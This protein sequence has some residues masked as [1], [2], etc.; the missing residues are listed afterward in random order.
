[1]I[2]DWHVTIDPI[3]T[4]LWN[5]TSSDTTKKGNEPWWSRAVTNAISKPFCTVFLKNGVKSRNEKLSG[6]VGRNLFSEE[7]PRK[8]SPTCYAPRADKTSHSFAQFDSL[9]SSLTQFGVGVGVGVVVVEWKSCAQ[10]PILL[11][12]E[13]W[14][15]GSILFAFFCA[16]DWVRLKDKRG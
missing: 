13:A 8:S 16:F 4:G 6:R 10:E 3:E 1:M 7:S 14:L 11:E 12:L 5:A 15:R 2:V 9:P